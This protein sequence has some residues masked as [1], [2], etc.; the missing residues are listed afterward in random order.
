M[1]IEVPVE[2]A[3]VW[4]K[5]DD[6]QLNLENLPAELAKYHDNSFNA[7]LFD[8]SVRA[9]PSTIEANT[10]RLLLDPDDRTPVPPF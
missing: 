4:T 7:A 9:I 3:T 8:G 6:Y 1:V 10:L 2:Q 5:P